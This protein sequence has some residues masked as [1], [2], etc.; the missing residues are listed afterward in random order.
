[1]DLEVIRDTVRRYQKGCAAAQKDFRTTRY[2]I[3]VMSAIIVTA[4]VGVAGTVFHAFVLRSLKASIQTVAI[5]S[6]SLYLVLLVIIVGT[7]FLVASFFVS[8][9]LE[10]YANREPRDLH[11]WVQ[12]LLVNPERT[13]QGSYLT[14]THIRWLAS[15]TDE[16]DDEDDNDDIEGAVRDDNA[17]D[18]NVFIHTLPHG[19][20]MPS[21]EELETLLFF[22]GREGAQPFV[23]N[24]AFFIRLLSEDRLGKR[25]LTLFPGL[26]RVYVA[27]SVQV[28][29]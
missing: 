15:I 18:P 5:L 28:S 10:V 23:S 25:R 24:E 4:I 13:A 14:L 8:R 12:N 3:I 29:A 1:M 11:S 20:C 26:S 16:D 2:N 6:V 17:N 27:T 21:P 22:Y 9:T 7:I 19:V